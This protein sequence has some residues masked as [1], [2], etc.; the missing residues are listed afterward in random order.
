MCTVSVIGLV[1]GGAVGYRL[2]SNR[3]ESP[4][5]SPAEAP[6]WRELGD[7]LRGLWPTDPGASG[8]WI[9]VNDA[10]LALAILNKNSGASTGTKGA[11]SRGT[12]IPRLL[13]A[14]TLDGADLMFKTLDLSALLPFRMLGIGFGAADIRAWSWSWDGASFAA[15]RDG[16]VPLCL[17]S[18][19][20][21]DALVEPRLD[22]FRDMVTS[23]PT[24]AAQ[25]AFHRHRWQDRPE[26]SVWMEREGART[27]SI[28]VCEV[29]AGAGNRASVSLEYTALDTPLGTLG[30]LVG[31]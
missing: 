22:L 12:L 4:L 27:V 11:T 7:G 16:R 31:S 9:G 8:T 3:D 13:S 5:R 29:F 23:D 10:G 20:L 26:T 25:D 28:S 6:A 18:S 15:R 1:R 24:P 21:G 2:V 19:G 30:P 14:S 17:A